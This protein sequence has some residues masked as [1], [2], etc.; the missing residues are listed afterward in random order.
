[1]NTEGVEVW[2]S[3]MVGGPAVTGGRQHTCQEAPVMS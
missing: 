1:M 2:V 3:R